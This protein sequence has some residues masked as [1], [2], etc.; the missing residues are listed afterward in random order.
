MQAEGKLPVPVS[1][2]AEAGPSTLTR[3]PSSSVPSAAGLTTDP[4]PPRPQA[5]HASRRFCHKLLAGSPP[6]PVCLSTCEVTRQPSG[7]SWGSSTERQAQGC[8]DDDMARAGQ[9]RGRAQEEALFLE[10]PPFGGLG[11]WKKKLGFY[12]Q[13]LSLSACHFPDVCGLN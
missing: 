1:W 7:C 5:P 8:R 6:H 9:A 2:E 12:S 11:F 3:G 10:I 13:L 4:S